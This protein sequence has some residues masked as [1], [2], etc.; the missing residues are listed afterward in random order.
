[1]T[2][3]PKPRPIFIA[4]LPREIASIVEKRGWRAHQKLLSRKI[5]LFEH[6]DAVIACAGMGVDRASL[7]V[8]A[9]MDLGPAAELISIGWAGSCSFRAKVGDIVRPTI[10]CDIRTGER[11]GTQ[12][13][14]QTMAEGK[15][16]EHHILVTIPKP[17]GAHAKKL[18]SIDYYADAVDM[19]ASTV[20]RIALAHDIPFNAIKAISDGP[21]FE[22][23]DLEKFT[24]PDGQFREA[25]FGLHVALRPN[26]WKPV[27][28]LAKGST[29]AAKRLS[30][31]I[32]AHILKYR[33]R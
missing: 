11:I 9:A 8:G 16:V 33:D 14:K 3:S 13:L 6:E 28:T 27:L 21:D 4:A 22:L 32:E 25:A 10:V 29:L 20:G 17:A 19:E 23:P 5:H 30:T 1:M 15:P 12:D 2:N 18:I 7:A 31:E 26:L 24:T